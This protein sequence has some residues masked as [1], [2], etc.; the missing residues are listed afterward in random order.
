M[1]IY[2]H[3][4]PGSPMSDWQTLQDHSKAVADMAAAFAGSFA[5]GAYGRLIGELHDVGKARSAFQSYLKRCNGIEDS[6]AD[7]GNHSHSS[8]GACWM[9]KNCGAV[10]KVLAYSVA[11]HHAGLPDWSGGEVPDGALVQRL[12]ND[13]AVLDESAVRDWIAQYGSEWLQGKLAPP[14]WFRP[15]DSSVSFWIRMMYS[16]LVDA[17]FLDTEAFMDPERAALRPSAV[18]L[19]TLAERFFLKL[20]EKQRS[21]TDTPVNRIRSEIRT[22]CESAAKMPPGL[23]SLTVPT[24]GGKTL[25]GTAFA[26]RHALR[27]G[28]KR[29][30]YVIPYTSIIE[31]TADILRGFLGAENVLEHHSNFDP[32]K[33]T[34]QSRLA[35]ENWDAPVVV[36]TAVQF[37]ESLYACKSSR[38]RKL[39]NIAESVVILDEVQLLPTRLLLPCAEAIRQLAEH[40]HTSVVLSTATQINLPSVDM[41]KVREM[42]PLSL[43]LYS[44]LKRTQI[45]FPADRSIRQTWDDIATMLSEHDQVLCIVNRRRDAVELFSKMPEGTIHLSAS[46]CGAHRSQVIA[47]IKSRLARSETVRVVS[48]QLVEAGVDIDFP[49]VYRAFAGLSSVAQSAGRCNR[50]GSLDVP[51]KVVVFIP[52]ERSPKGELLQGEYAMEDLLDRPDGVDPDDSQSFPDYFVRMHHRVRDLGTAFRGWLGVPVPKEF[53]NGIV[54]SAPTPPQYQFHEAAKA[55]QMIDNAQTPVIVRYGGSDSLIDSLQKTGPKCDIMRKLQRYSVNVPRGMIS[56]LLENG[57]VEE[58]Y[59]PPNRD[60]PS[61]IYVQAAPSAYREDIGLDIFGD[62]LSTEDCMI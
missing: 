37:F 36:T 30:I 13:S 24:G 49:V 56:K 51:G 47:E 12:M 41:S 29:V 45:E 48:T 40:Y 27:H 62:G 54:P 58:L 5:C 46:M 32:E 23:F 50:E 17:D 33:E 14:S 60:L 3:S 35:S 10:G 22:A 9:A 28:L 6:E 59:L 44:R 21:A 55:F 16:C 4:K 11:G 20:D 19:A 8:V 2:A 42:I 43:N 39:H 18:P 26:F 15:N 34:P 53:R 52:P 7:F 31:Q 61:G 1:S 57:T 38:C 25:S